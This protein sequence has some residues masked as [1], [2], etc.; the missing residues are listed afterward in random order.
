[1]Y[2]GG[3]ARMRTLMGAF[4]VLHGLA[5]TVGILGTWTRVDVGFRDEPW[6]LPGRVR[7]R[8]PIG[9]A[10]GA[11]WLVALIG[12][13]VAGAGA[14]AGTEWWPAL[15]VGSAVVSLAAMVPWWGAMPPGVR[16]GVLANVV[17]VVALLSPLGRG[18][19]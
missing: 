11:V 9:Y 18:V 12:W 16:L 19:T 14:I 5:H 6:L 8:S 3:D 2:G 15:A 7:L 17:V 13:V 1:M 4:F 10:F